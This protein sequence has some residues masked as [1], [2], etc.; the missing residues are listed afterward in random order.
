MRTQIVLLL[1]QVPELMNKLIL[2]NFKPN[3]KVDD[4]ELHSFR[5]TNE[6]SLVA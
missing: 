4:D 6:P 3:Y 2:N 1:R 5:F